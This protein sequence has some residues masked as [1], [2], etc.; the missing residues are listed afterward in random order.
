MAVST[1]QKHTGFIYDSELA[2]G[3]PAEYRMQIQRTIAAKCA[4]ASRMDL[5]QSRQDGSYGLE[6]LAEVHARI[7]QLTAPPPAK[8]VKALPIPNAYKKARRGGRRARAKK[9]SLQTTEMRK[10]QNRLA[11][12]QEEAELGYDQEEGAGMLGSMG[13]KLRVQADNKSKGA[14]VDYMEKSQKLIYVAKMSKRNQ[15]RTRA[16]ASGTA[17]MLSGTATSLAIG[18]VQGRIPIVHLI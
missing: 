16:L 10:L 6:C 18:S 8:L 9:E 1:V 14:V 3:V 13:S 5:D 2:Q 12:G 4:K 17:T 7:E 15:L 11:F